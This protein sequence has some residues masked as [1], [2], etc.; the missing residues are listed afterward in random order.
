MAQGLGRLPQ[1]W[2]TCSWVPTPTPRLPAC[3]WAS[4]FVSL[5]RG[6]PSVRRQRF[7]SLQ[8]RLH[9]VQPARR[10]LHLPGGEG[11]TFSRQPNLSRSPFCHPLK[12]LNV[13]ALACLQRFA[14]KFNQRRWNRLISKAPPKRRF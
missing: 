14:S 1:T 3:P 8:H 13:T 11:A 9:L 2:E 7:S 12:G 6:S 5:P 10:H 4:P